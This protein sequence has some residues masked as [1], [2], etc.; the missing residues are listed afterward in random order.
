MCRVLIY[1][2]VIDKYGKE[3]KSNKRSGADVTVLLQF[4]SSLNSFLGNLINRKIRASK[5]PLPAEP[6]ILLPVQLQHS[7]EMI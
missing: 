3:W 1:N 6:R 5:D 4:Q 7:G 2:Y